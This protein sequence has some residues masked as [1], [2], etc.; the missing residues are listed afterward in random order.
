MG[1]NRALT[2]T[3]N[4][5][6]IGHLRQQLVQILERGSKRSLTTTIGPKTATAQRGAS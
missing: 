2:K 3:D 6:R 1:R 5:Y 4:F